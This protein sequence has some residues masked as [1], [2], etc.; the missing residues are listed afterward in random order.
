MARCESNRP[1]AFNSFVRYKKLAGFCLILASLHLFSVSVKSQIKI[2]SITKDMAPWSPAKEVTC[3]RKAT[4][5]PVTRGMNLEIGDKLY[6]ES[7]SIKVKVD[8]RGVPYF[9]T[10][11]FSVKFRPPTS[12]GCYTGF[13]GSATINVKSRNI[14]TNNQVGDFHAITPGTEY[15]LRITG[16]ESRHPMAR[17]FPFLFRRAKILEAV[18]YEGTMRIETPKGSKVIGPGQKA[19][20]V[21]NREPEIVSVTPDDLRQAAKVYAE[22]EVSQMSTTDPQER[23]SA[24]LKLVELHVAVLA[25]PADPGSK[26]ELERQL[27]ELKVSPA[28]EPSSSYGP[29]QTPEDQTPNLQSGL[30]NEAIITLTNGCKKPQI[31]R[32]TPQNLPFPRRPLTFESVLAPGVETKVR[33][34]FNT[35]GAKP[36]EY[37]GA[38]LIE[39]LDCKKDCQVRKP[40]VPITIT[41]K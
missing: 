30:W 20:V 18:M 41:K 2:V 3:M 22:F 38:V 28:D 27:T 24:F 13:G 5:P 23:N 29:P 25:N 31:Y 15:K 19:I 9:F 21:N 26:I 1:D 4:R 40:Q 12:P 7:P 33:F 11:P 6:S 8:C 39:C 36:G 37:H 34:E 16:R 10:G 32:L 17:F 14:P 35:A